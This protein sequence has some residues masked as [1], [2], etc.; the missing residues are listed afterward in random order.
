MKTVFLL[1]FAA[2]GLQAKTVTIPQSFWDKPVAVDDY[3]VLTAGFNSKTLP[4]A[5][6]YALGAKGIG[7]G[8]YQAGEQGR[9]GLAVATTKLGGFLR[10]AGGSNL[11]P[12]AATVRMFVKGKFLAGKKPKTF[13]SALGPDYSVAVIKYQDS[14][15]LELRKLLYHPSQGNRLICSVKMPIAKLVG[16]KWYSVVAS[17]DRNKR[18]GAIFL[19]GK[20][21][22]GKLT[23]PEN[24]REF[25]CFN[26]ASGARAKNFPDGL[27]MPGSMFDELQVYNGWYEDILK[28]VKKL[29]DADEKKLKAMLQAVRNYGHVAEKLQRWGG[30]ENL[31]TWPNMFGSEAQGRGLIQYPE[32]ISN[33]KSHSTALIAARLLY[34]WQVMGDYRFYDLAKRS[35][36]FFLAAQSKQGYWVNGYR[37]TVNGIEPKHDEKF[38]FQDSVQSHPIFLLGYFYRISGEK[39]YLA[40]AKKAGELYLKYQN[41]DGSWSHHGNAVKKI[42]ETARGLPQGGEI[43]DLA[44][45]D[46]IDV[47]VFMY[48]LTGESKYIKAIKRLGDWMIKAE[49][50]GTKVRGWAQQYDNKM[51]PTDARHFEPPAMSAAGTGESIMALVE[52]Y[53]LSKDRKYLKVI[54]EC[55]DWFKKQF[56]NGMYQ[57]YEYESGR[58][59]AYWNRKIYYLDDPKQLAFIKT[60]PINM[61]NIRLNKLPSFDYVLKTADDYKFPQKYTEKEMRAMQKYINKNATMGLDT[62]SKD[63]L[64]L[65]PWMSNFPASLGQG[66]TLSQGRLLWMINWIEATRM[67]KGEIPPVQ[68][69]GTFRPGTIEIKRLAWPGNWYDV[70]WNKH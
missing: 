38:K 21:L 63:G 2:I 47:M 45:N 60:V 15:A 49:L 37:M 57:Y 64:W 14:L 33:D 32:C 58:P 29:S 43:N 39:K 18:Q 6:D 61:T 46:S 66:F 11:S 1:L 52:L 34:A 13:F 3:T 35:C 54:E 65:R 48:H 23:F 5:A 24:T 41:P 68:R 12:A 9:F 56:P 59:V 51:K 53:R 22:S 10:F 26:L 7:G 16:D 42:G 44:C 31:Y 67:L 27:S 25:L 70:D 62:I 17:W 19:D 55:R 69:G 40:A 28:P 20:G 30:W 36:D 8:Q 50:K 4:I